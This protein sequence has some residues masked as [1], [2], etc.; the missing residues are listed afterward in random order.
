MIAFTVNL[1]NERVKAQFTAKGQKAQ[2]G[3]LGMV[4]IQLLSVYFIGLHVGKP[5]KI[6]RGRK[7]PKDYFLALAAR[8][9]S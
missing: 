5:A 1:E 7:P 2:E 9:S 6:E 8:Y 4:N 3:A